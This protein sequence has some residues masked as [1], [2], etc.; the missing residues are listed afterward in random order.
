MHDVNILRVQTNADGAAHPMEIG[1]LNQPLEA[2]EF[3]DN[4]VVQAL[5]GHRGNGA[6]QM[7]LIRRHDVDILGADNH[8]HR[9]VGREALVHA[10]KDPAEEPNLVIG[11]HHAVQ[12]V[13][14]ADKIR[15]EG[16]LRLIIDI[17]RSA[18]LLNPS[19]VHNHDGVG[20]GKRL[21]LVVGYIDKGNAHGLLDSFQLVLHILAQAQIQRA[22]GFVQ[23]QYLGL[24]HQRP[25]DSHPLLLSAG[26]AVDLPSFIALQTDDLQHIPYP[27]VDLVLRQLGHPQAEGYVVV[28]IQMREQGIALKHG[29]DLAFVGRYV[30]E[31]RSVKGHRAGGGGQKPADDPQRGGFAAAGR[32]EQCEEFMIIDIKIDVVENTLPVELHGKIPESD[33]FLGHYPP[34]F[35]SVS[36]P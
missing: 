31:Y 18:D 32:A 26:K 33:E 8:V 27:P 34:P 20:H 16:V 12:N 2:L 15:H 36:M 6:N 1:G 7:T 4:I 23:Q 35:L 22:Q 19:P 14:F 28:D 29:V 24:V 30:I 3:H 11:Q 5:K 21:F 10:V 17:L 13:A 9:L 25:G